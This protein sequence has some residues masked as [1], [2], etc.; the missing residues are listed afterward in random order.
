MFVCLLKASHLYVTDLQ[1][2]RASLWT[3]NVLMG[4]PSHLSLQGL[5]LTINV[6]KLTLS[7]SAALHLKRHVYVRPQP[8]EMQLFSHS[9]LQNPQMQRAP[10]QSHSVTSIYGCAC[11]TN[12]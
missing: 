5:K 7:N 9:K 1:W 10:V 4:S 6:W 3:D 2:Y 11:L 8:V 12:A